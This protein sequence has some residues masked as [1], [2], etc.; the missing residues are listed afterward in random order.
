MNFADLLQE[1]VARL[2]EERRQVME[3]MVQEFGAGD[4]LRLLLA[5]ATA[6]NHRERQLVRLLLRDLEKIED[7][8]EKEKSG[9]PRQ[10][11][12]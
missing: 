3:A 8:Q 12:R 9:E 10:E 11:R 1:V 7:Q 4:S 2:P 5:L 6:A